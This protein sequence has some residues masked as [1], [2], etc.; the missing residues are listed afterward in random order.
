M[1]VRPTHITRTSADAHVTILMWSLTDAGG[2][3]IV[4][5]V[6]APHIACVHVIFFF[7]GNDSL[8]TAM[9]VRCGIN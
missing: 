7:R 3:V 1:S 9:R 4:S 8:M 6:V 2:L 5:Q